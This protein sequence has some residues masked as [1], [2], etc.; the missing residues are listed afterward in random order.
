LNLQ[1]GP[2]RD[3]TQYY[4]ALDP[5]LAKARARAAAAQEDM[6]E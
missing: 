5:A 3:A 6:D 2:W 4:Q 1:R